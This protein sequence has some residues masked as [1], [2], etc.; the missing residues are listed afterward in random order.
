[1]LL[2]PLN[3]SSQYVSMAETAGLKVL[4]PPKDISKDVARTWYVNLSI[5]PSIHPSIHLSLSS[6][7]RVLG[8]CAPTCLATLCTYNK[9]LPFD[10][11]ISHGNSCRLHLYGHLPSVKAETVLL[12]FRLL[13]R[14]VADTLMGLSV[15]LSWRLR[16]RD[17]LVEI[18]NLRCGLMVSL[19]VHARKRI[20]YVREAVDGTRYL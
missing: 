13:G 16:R 8:Q 7:L 2:P 14:C 10:T 4:H 18:C 15:T 1:M 11:G 20:R 19:Y 12:S 5:Y 17:L 9:L 6:P 3:T